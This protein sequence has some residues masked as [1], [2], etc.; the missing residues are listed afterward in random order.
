VS[1]YQV[2]TYWSQETAFGPCT[3]KA[4]GDALG[5]L[6][7]RPAPGQMRVGRALAAPGNLCIAFS[8]S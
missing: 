3:V 6:G 5:S 8:K 4:T 7:L 1:N 2:K